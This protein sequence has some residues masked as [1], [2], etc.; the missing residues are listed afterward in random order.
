MIA[1]GERV[2][3]TRAALVAIGAIFFLMGIVGSAYGPL[4]EQLARRFDVSLA[5]AGG[6]L[7]THFSGALVG[8]LVSMRVLQRVSSR[9]F[10]LGALTCLGVGCASVALAPSWF[11]FLASVF[12]LGIG[13]GALDIGCNQ[14]VAHSEGVRRTAIL[15]GL[16]GT[17][18][19]GAVAGPILVSTV[20]RTHLA[21]L[22]GGAAA[23]AFALW[24][25]VSGV[26]GRLPFIP[27]RTQD[28][29]VFLLAIFMVAFALYVGMEAGIGGWM[30]SHLESIGVQSVAAATLTSGFWL[31]LAAGRL[32]A[33]LVPARVP[34]RAIVITGSA[35][36]AIALSAALIPA[37]AP[38]AFIVAGL[39][40]APIFP[41]GIVWLAKLRPGDARVTSWLFPASMVGGAIIPGGIG[42]VIA[43]FGIGIAPAV[44][45]LVA[46]GCVASFSLA[47]R[48]GARGMVGER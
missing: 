12:V 4:L 41:T 19:V 17:F 43:R 10:M 32:L 39:A 33:A 28:S 6:V 21:L 44:L 13:W 24:P 46:V 45:S 22:Y 37:V 3:L 23:V 7:T 11:A 26:S 15:N 20:G 18:A 25:L 5:V 8:V 34:E 48:W 42:A 16:N 35:V 9:T 38:V 27:S 47:A 40:I 31:A 36:S 2:H 29:S 14:L 30:P 1:T